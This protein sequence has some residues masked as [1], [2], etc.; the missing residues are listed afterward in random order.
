LILWYLVQHLVGTPVSALVDATKTIAS[1]Q[2]DYQM[3]VTKSGEFEHL[4]NSFNR[5]TRKLSDAQRQLY[6]SDKLAS[7][8]RLAA[9]VA[10]EINNPLTGVLTYSS[11]LLK[12]DGFS[13]EVTNDLNVIVNE[14]KRCREIVK[15]LLDFARPMPAEKTA[16]D[17]PEIVGRTLSILEGQLRKKQIVVQTDF[18]RHPSPVH[19]DPNQLQQIL[20]NLVVNAMDAIGKSGGTIKISSFDETSGGD[21]FVKIQVSDSGSGIAREDLN[22]I[23]EPFY[24]TKGTEGTGLGLSVVWGIMEEHDAKISVESEKDQGTTFILSFPVEQMSPAGGPVKSIDDSPNHA[25]R[26]FERR[27]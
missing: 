5:M 3:A 9:G 13:E 25:P 6:Q 20:V 26:A 16:V 10:H 11:M 21:S 1:G 24:T 12:H 8:G 15:R 7:I 4:G 19:A 27:F 2:L 18:G 22:K 14:T 23:F 17:V